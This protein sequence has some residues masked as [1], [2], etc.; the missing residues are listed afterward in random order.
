MSDLDVPATKRD[1]L[2]FAT[3]QDVRDLRQDLRHELDKLNVKIDAYWTA[4]DSSCA[5]TALPIAR[6]QPFPF[7]LAEPVGAEAPRRW[8]FEMHP[9]QLRRI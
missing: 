9:I 7:P 8:R 5:K 2:D 6:V 4:S 1:L 3:K